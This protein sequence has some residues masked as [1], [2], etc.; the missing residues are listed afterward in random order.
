MINENKFLSLT[1]TA[2]LSMVLIT[3]VIVL[4]V[5]CK[6]NDDMPPANAI[7]AASAPSDIITTGI[8]QPEPAPSADTT[9][10][11]P[12]DPIDLSAEAQGSQI[13]LLLQ[14]DDRW[15]NNSF[16]GS[17]I[18]AA[19]CGPTCLSMA[20]LYLTGDATYTPAY[21]ASYADSNGYSN[22]G[23]GSTWELIT[24]GAESIGLSCA[25]VPLEKTVMMRLATAGIPMICSM[26]P[27]TFTAEGHYIVITG[28]SDGKFTVND[29]NSAEK[30][31]ATYSF[32]ELKDQIRN[33]WALYGSRLSSLEYTV[34]ES[35]INVRDDASI[36]SNVKYRASVE[37]RFTID[38]IANGGG[39]VWGHMNDGNW[40]CLS[41]VK[42]AV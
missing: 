30:S 33:T 34:T 20:A 38:K 40:I 3:S 29:P 14:T 17:T 2:G 28:V 9:T 6:K 36:S 1:I 39:Y 12:A 7:N 26:G 31:A 22:N 13:P 4:A 41:Y 42:K 8:S 19:G 23:D 21:M 5:S 15:S 10:Q 32:E 37:K 11:T 35:G 16:A 25:E 18:G 27:G 24:Q